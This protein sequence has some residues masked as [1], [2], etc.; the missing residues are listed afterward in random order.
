MEENKFEETEF[1]CPE[2]GEPIYK[3][4]ARVDDETTQSYDY[5]WFH[6][7]KNGCKLSCYNCIHGQNSHGDSCGLI[8][9][10]IK[11]WK[12]NKGSIEII[13]NLNNY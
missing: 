5:K 8:C 9:R 1:I 12:P 3:K 13:D 7:V 2:C 10:G 11:Q 6:C 4:L